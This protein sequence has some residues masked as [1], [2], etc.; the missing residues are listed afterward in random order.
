MFH[1]TCQKYPRSCRDEE[2][3][4]VL[5]I[6]LML[7]LFF[8]FIAALVLDIAR[9][10][11]VTLDLQQAADAAS[12]AGAA[13]L[14]P[15]PDSSLEASETLGWR[16]AKVLAFRLLGRN[17]VFSDGHEVNGGPLAAS[18][19]T[20]LPT[21]IYD[22]SDTWKCIEFDYPNLI[23][24]IERGIYYNDG[25]GQLLFSSMENLPDCCAQSPCRDHVAYCSSSGVTA[26]PPQVS[27]AVRVA[28]TLKRIPTIF[29]GILHVGDVRL[30]TRQ[31]VS[32]L[33]PYP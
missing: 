4:A 12:L 13:V 16:A 8:L 29:A 3:G 9:I 18:S 20:D 30:I 32:S 31:A 11:R 26:E 7:I 1:N 22:T 5:I 15:N 28:L 33:Q 27:N 14:K 19:C 25:S 2:R 23:V 21:P 6:G 24:R 17:S 10:E